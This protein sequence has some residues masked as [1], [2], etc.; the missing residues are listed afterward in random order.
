MTYKPIPTRKFV[1]FLKELGLEHK[2]TKGDH[3]IW[4]YPANSK[5]LRPVTFITKEKTIP[6]LHIRTNLI[7]LGISYKK[8]LEILSKL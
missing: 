4:D 7:N 1:K 8:F 3:E 5:L 6:P 2:R